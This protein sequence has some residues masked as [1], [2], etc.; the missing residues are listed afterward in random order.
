[1]KLFVVLFTAFF[2]Y[3]TI[4]VIAFGLPSV[5]AMLGK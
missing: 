4:G 1:M 3:E 5:H 2:I